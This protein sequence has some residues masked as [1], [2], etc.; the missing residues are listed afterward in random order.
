M[1]FCDGQ[2]QPGRLQ[3]C[4]PG[5]P[6]NPA[7]PGHPHH[8]HRLLPLLLLSPC[9]RMLLLLPGLHGNGK[10]RDKKEE[11]FVKRGRP[12]DLGQTGGDDGRQSCTG[13]GVKIKTAGSGSLRNPLFVSVLKVDVENLHLRCTFL[14]HGQ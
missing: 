12:V 10:V 2:T 9:R 5:G 1:E 3:H 4:V 7:P 14:H 8:L 6:A 11:K 13:N